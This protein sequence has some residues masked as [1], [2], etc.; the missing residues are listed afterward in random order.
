MNCAEARR[1]LPALLYGDLEL[2]AAGAVRQHLAACPACRR[3]HAALDRVR[4]ALDTVPVPV[5]QVDLP[6]LYQEA[7]ARQARCVRTWRRTALA[8]AAV[9]ALLLVVFGLRLQVRVGP[10]EMVLRWGDVPP[11]VTPPSSGAAEAD[12]EVA[13][14][15]QLMSEL[16]HALA[17]DLESRDAQQ[18][19]SLK[20]LQARLDALHLQN[21]A[22]W[23]E[24]RRD[25][26]ALYVARFGP[27]RKGE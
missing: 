21:D 3:E 20:R 14:R 13:Q 9:A 16:I 7:A 23:G 26:A 5:V 27:P 12:A 24:A 15:L 2:G 4:A 1:H 25:I 8:C 6:R 18:R 22:R 19:D 11:A 17:D 10:H